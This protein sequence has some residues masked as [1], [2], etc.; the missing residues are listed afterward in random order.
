MATGKRGAALAGAATPAGTAALAER[1]AAVSRLAYGPLGRTGLTVSRLGFGGYRV[2]VETAAHRA[3]L[4]QALGSG[5]NLVDTSTNYADGGSEELVGQVVGD[6]AGTGRIAR[7]ATVVVSKIGYVQGQNLALARERDAEGRPFPEM[8]RYQASCWHCVHPA[9]LE[10]QL[11]RSLARLGLETLDVCLLHNPEYFFSDAAERREGPIESL[12]DEFYRRLEG[13]FRFFETQVAAG[14]LRWYGVSSNTIARAVDDP[15]ATSLTRM[16]AAARGAG[17]PD[18]HFAVLQLPLNLFEAEGALQATDPPAGPLTARRS[19]LELAAREGLGVLVNRPLNA[20]MGRGTVR[21]ADFPAPPAGALARELAAVGALEAEYRSEIASRLRVKPDSD[22]PEDF[23]RWA[24]QLAAIRER[25]SGVTYWEQVEWQ[26]RGMTARVIRALDQGLAGETAE[27]WR[28][29]R[30]RY[31]PALERLL[32]AF[33]ADAAGRS[34]RESRAVGAALDPALPGERRGAPLSQKAL[35]VVA[36]TPGVS[37]V[38]V[39]MR[40]PAYVEDATR[41]L[42]WPPLADAR[43]VYTTLRGLSLPGA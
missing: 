2:D 41:I 8:V 3:A 13:A 9:F 28:G 7:E 17:G 21:L 32:G 35:W 37:T 42:D 22:Q 11:A 33:R 10:D 1:R 14:R 36:S 25:I 4:E 5:V 23:L 43:S 20:V 12:R 26:V 18:H 31:R 39:G 27:R 29:F 16:L 15:E 38:L 40:R 24:E 6:L 19:V 34:Q 30:D